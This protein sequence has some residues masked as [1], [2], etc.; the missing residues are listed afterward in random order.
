MKKGK[1]MICCLLALALLLIPCAMG[2][3]AEV[4]N[5]RLGDSEYVVTVPASFQA[6]GMSE[7]DIADGQVGYYY[8]SETP[9]D[10]DV[11][12]FDKAPEGITLAEYAEEEAA[13]YQG[14]TDLVTDAGI[15]GVVLA[16]YHAIENYEGEDYETVTFI[17]ESGDQF[18]EMVFWLDGEQALAEMETI[19]E[20]LRVE[21]GEPAEEEYAEDEADAAEDEED[22]AG[23]EEDISEDEDDAEY[24]EAPMGSGLDFNS[25]ET[26]D[27]PEGEAETE[28]AEADEPEGEIDDELKEILADI[29][30]DIVESDGGESTPE[31]YVDAA[32]ESIDDDLMAEIE[33]TLSDEINLQLGTS[34]FSI[35]V[36]PEYHN[37]ELTEEDIADDMVAFY[38][39]EDD[40]PD[41]DVYHFA[42]DGVDPD[43]TA[44]A[45]DEAAEY[46]GVT[47]VVGGDMINDIPVAWYR[48]VE[49]Y[50]GETYVTRTYILD[51][52]DSY[53]EVV[54]WMEDDEEIDRVIEIMDTLREE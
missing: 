51:A 10:F 22:A 28:Y 53:V 31:E 42:K 36:P 48:A 8:S 24:L 45:M 30:R 39:G 7:D 17:M 47:E 34:P 20:T 37:G 46:K 38:E 52:G 44:Y 35:T 41:F 54:F 26:G 13:Q 50:E 6:G 15:N 14:V 32:M 4:T 49:E 1:R 21:G 25:F 19:V 40:L 2:E 29:V 27:I 23:D 11:Y 16:W 43:L 5:L 33:S 18:V 3:A 12:Q 9:L